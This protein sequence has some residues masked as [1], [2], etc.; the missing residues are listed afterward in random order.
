MTRPAARL[1]PILPLGLSVLLGLPAP[2]D[3]AP[4]AKAAPDSEAK[5]EGPA[6]APAKPHKG[7]DSYEKKRK[8]VAWI[9]RW[10]PERNLIEIGVY[11]GLFFPSDEH[12]FY[13]PETRP[14]KPLWR[15]NGDVGLRLASA[16]RSG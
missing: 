2:A 10:A 15:L 14:Q 7:V 3:A 9:R 16:S 5:A 8:D 6:E 1:L 13:N 11:G 4:P 12:D